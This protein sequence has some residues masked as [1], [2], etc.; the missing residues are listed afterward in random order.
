MLLGADEQV[1]VW[2]QHRDPAL[3]LCDAF[4]RGGL[5]PVWA[6]SLPEAIAVIDRSF[7][8]AVACS[9]DENAPSLI[10]LETLLTY[11][12]IGHGAVSLPTVP[13]WGLTATPTTHGPRIEE[14]E[15]PINMVPMESGLEGLAAE[16]VHYLK[17]HCWQQVASEVENH[18]VVYLGPEP[19]V[20]FY[21]SRYL[22]ARGLTTLFIGGADR[23]LQ[24]LEDVGFQAVVLDVPQAGEGQALLA[25]IGRRWPAL[26]IVALGEP[27]GW[28]AQLS[29]AAL[30]SGLVCMLP[31]PVKAETL[32]ACL[33]RLLRTQ[34][35]A[36]RRPNA[37]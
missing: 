8:R 23:L 15:L 35:T 32:E 2:M 28:L 19:R 1:L 16:V 17:H 30:P 33:R 18:A 5:V 24:V 29:P 9:L 31:K 3:Q 27:S 20:G 6:A 11:L 34:T 10:D 26:P 7:P 4:E 13:I 22:G 21:L 25:E 36:H 37:H 14:L 12:T